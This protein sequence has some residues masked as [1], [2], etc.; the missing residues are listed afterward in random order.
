M[1]KLGILTEQKANLSASNKTIYRVQQI[2]SG[3]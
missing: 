3:F 2:D 1:L